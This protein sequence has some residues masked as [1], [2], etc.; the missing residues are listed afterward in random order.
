MR[1]D[2]LFAALVALSVFALVHA[3]VAPTGLP[4][5]LYHPAL[6]R[7]SFGPPGP[8]L[9]AYYGEIA[10]AV[11]GAVLAGLGATLATRA[12]PAGPRLLAAVAAVASAAVVVDLVVLVASTARLS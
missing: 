6:H 10:W 8:G 5:L 12:R 11:L 4:G 7:W 2:R 9:M 1:G 3:V